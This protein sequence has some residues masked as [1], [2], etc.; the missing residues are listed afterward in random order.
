VVVRKLTLLAALVMCLTLANQVWAGSL[1]FSGTNPNEQGNLFFNPISNGGPGVLNIGAGAAINGGLGALIS[2]MFLMIPQCGGAHD[3]A[4]TGNPFPGGYLTLSNAHESGV[5]G[6]TYTFSGGKVTIIGGISALGIG[7]GSTLLTMNFL[8]GMTFTVTGN[9][10]KIAGNI[11]VGS[12]ML[13]STILT[14]LGAGF[15]GFTDGNVFTETI[16]LDPACSTGGVC[17]GPLFTTT[18]TLHYIPEPATLSVLGVG[19][20]AFGTGLRRKMAAK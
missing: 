15:K 3:C 11:D 6:N 4:V 17:R 8:P 13:N 9:T 10:G 18:A 7:N 1:T 19:L 12:I 2:D 16:G 5:S 20:F 14:A